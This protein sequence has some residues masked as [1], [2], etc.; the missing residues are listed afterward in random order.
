MGAQH[1]R[2]DGRPWD[3]IVV[4]GGPAGLAAALMLGRY[5]RRALL[6]DDGRPRNAATRAIHGVP[7]LDGV[8]P[9]ELRERARAEIARYPDIRCGEVRVARAWQET[10]SGQGACLAVETAAGTVERA[11]CLLLATGVADLRPDDVAGFDALYGSDIHHC[12]DCDGYEAS[13]KR[14]A[15]LSW[16][17]EATSYALELL[18]WATDVT[19]LTHGHA[20]SLSRG[21]LARLAAVGIAVD[22][23]P[24][25]RFEERA[26]RLRGIRFADGDELPCETAFFS[27]GQRPRSELARQ[28]G[29]ALDERGFIEQDRRQRAS[30]LGVF[31]AGD[32]S[33]PDDTVAVAMAQGQVAAIMINRALH[34]PE[35]RPE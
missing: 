11:P 17:E 21:H 29:C 20:E 22:H 10:V 35:R 25:A 13:G 1:I 14:V 28:L 34:G 32:V 9:H 4:G 31:A 3:A 30:V 26:G 19:L 2:A 33:P 6:F 16:G 8:G 23:R 12:P 5:R 18:N 27:I 24:L 15:V 7:G